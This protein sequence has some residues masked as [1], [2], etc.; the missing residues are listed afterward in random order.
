ML[1]SIKFALK[2]YTMHL[3]AYFFPFQAAL[4]KHALH[5]IF[6]KFIYTSIKA[7][8]VFIFISFILLFLLIP[9]FSV[10]E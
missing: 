1:E 2:E 10:F 9:F 4:S 5:L 3:K 7:F 8:I 6:F